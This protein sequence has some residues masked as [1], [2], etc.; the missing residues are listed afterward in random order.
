MAKNFKQDGRYVDVDAPAGG[1]SSGDLVKVGS[2]FGVAQTDADAGDTVT[3]DTQ[4]VYE[5]PVASAVVVAVGDALYWDVADGEFNKT[6]ASNWFLGVAVTAAGN[7]V[8]SA[9]VRLNGA[10]P[11]AAGA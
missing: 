2:V 5:L 7:G 8:T 9:Q 11:A 10:M 3:L 1:V 6:A 4:G